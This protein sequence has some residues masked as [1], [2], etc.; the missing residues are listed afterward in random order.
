MF[1]PW[2]NAII[3][4]V[5]SELR[6][7]EAKEWAQR[8]LLTVAEFPEIHRSLASWTSSLTLY[9]TTECGYNLKNSNLTDL[10]TQDALG[11]QTTSFRIFVFTPRQASAGVALFP[12]SCSCDKTEPLLTDSTVISKSNLYFSSNTFASLLTWFVFH[13]RERK[14]VEQSHIKMTS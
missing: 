11:N 5:F 14:R 6:L 2:D 12:P 3:Q 8:F 10:M 4:T 1:V 13:A 9:P 7:C